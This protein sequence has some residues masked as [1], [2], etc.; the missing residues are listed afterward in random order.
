MNDDS[1]AV[2]HPSVASAEV[3]DGETRHEAELVPTVVA[4]D[5]TPIDLSESVKDAVLSVHVK[6]EIAALKVGGE[7]LEK[8]QE[9]E[10]G[11]DEISTSDN[12]NVVSPTV[13]KI[14]EPIPIT[15]VA[16][17][18]LLSTVP[19]SG[20]P[21]ATSTSLPTLSTHAIRP[22]TPSISPAPAKKFASSLSVNKKFLEK[23]GEKGK[24][25]VKSVPGSFRSLPNSPSPLCADL[26]SY[27]LQSVQCPSLCR[28]LALQSSLH[29][30]LDY[31]PAK[32]LPL[33][34]PLLSLQRKRMQEFPVGSRLSPSMD[35]R[36][37]HH[38]RRKRCQVDQWEEVL[39][40]EEPCEVWDEVDVKMRYGDIERADHKE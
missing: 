6:E 40:S 5:T 33:L 38:F 31:S 30:I 36:L 15:P 22:V 25:E 37:D 39:M 20:A 35:W 12:I 32:S 24:V 29:R 16:P 14:I 8:G 13:G 2:A 34:L 28:P 9:S 1:D 7:G 27:E 4:T 26:D 21:T 23:A 10:R 19:L 3:N 17:S 11:I 18:P